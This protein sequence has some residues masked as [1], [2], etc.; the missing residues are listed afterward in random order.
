M[1]MF[2]KSK[3]KFSETFNNKDGKT[4]GSGFSG[5]ILCLIGG[6]GFICGTFGYFFGIEETM[7]YLGE[8]LKL[9]AAG[10][11][12]L[13]VRKVGGQIV[14]A[15]NG[16]NPEVIKPEITPVVKPVVKPEV[17]NEELG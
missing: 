4:S 12:L 11:I 8:V 7:L 13:G 3:F 17:N 16:K 6:A 9:I 2:D 10:T 5:V 15:K 14:E 1:S